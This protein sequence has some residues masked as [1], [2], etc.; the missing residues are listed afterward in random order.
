MGIIIN[1]TTIF[2]YSYYQVFIYKNK[3]VKNKKGI[4]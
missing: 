4:I 2:N 1:K 3:R